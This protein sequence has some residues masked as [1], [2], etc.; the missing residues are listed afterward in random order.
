MLLHAFLIAP[1]PP[2]IDAKVRV[3]ANIFAPGAQAD[4]VQLVSAA[5]GRTPRLQPTEADAIRLFRNVVNWRAKEP[6]LD[7]IGDALA[8]SDKK[9]RDRMMA[10]VLG[11]VAAPALAHRD[12]TAE[13]AK[14][15]LKF[16]NETGLPESLSAW[17][18]FYGL[19]SE[20]NR[21]IEHAFYRPL[22]NGDRRATPAAVD[23]LDRWLRLSEREQ[24]SPMPDTLRDRALQA[25]ERGRTGGLAHL[26][27]LVR[28][29]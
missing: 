4:P 3:Y 13:Q 29:S 12:R 20:T 9:K 19:D 28:H 6:A 25:M 23:A 27:Y 24:A 17:P 15:V 2:D 22:A 10:L 1:A 8:Q 18:V 5:S 11:I 21:Q 16:F 7:T 26:I 14:A